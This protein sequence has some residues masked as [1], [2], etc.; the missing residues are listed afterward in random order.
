MVDRPQRALLNVRAALVLTVA[1]LAAV[2]AGL[3]AHAA[4]RS[5]PE[6]LLYAGTVFTGAVVLFNWMIGD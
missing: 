5:W 1:V 2:G 6:S 3:L 4:G